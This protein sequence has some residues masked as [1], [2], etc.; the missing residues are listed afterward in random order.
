VFLDDLYIV[1]SE[2]G[3]GLALQLQAPLMGS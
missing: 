3:H 2:R 1:P